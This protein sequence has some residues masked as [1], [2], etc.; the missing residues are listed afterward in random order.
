L[1]VK[2]TPFV[3]IYPVV[4]AAK[5]GGVIDTAPFRAV[6]LLTVSVPVAVIFAPVR[7]PLKNPLPAT[8]RAL[9]GEVV[10]IPTAP[11]KVLV[12]VVVEIIFPTVA[13][14][15]TTKAVEGVEEPIPTFPP[16]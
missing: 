11:A 15:L 10:P 3:P 5:V 1:K 14:P 2:F 9:D 8:S 6:L 12:A 13:V 7:L 16:L 4:V